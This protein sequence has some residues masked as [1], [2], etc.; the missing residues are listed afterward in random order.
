MGQQRKT[1]PVL[2]MSQGTPIVGDFVTA[3]S[4]KD[5]EWDGKAKDD[6]QKGNFIMPPEAD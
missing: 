6:G 4:G 3:I 1:Q 5:G 2:R